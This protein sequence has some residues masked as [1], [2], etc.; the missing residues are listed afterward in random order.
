M[1]SQ[2]NFQDN[3][4]LPR[5]L[6]SLRREYDIDL[7]LDFVIE[8]VGTALRLIGINTKSVK[9]EKMKVVNG[10][11]ITPCYTEQI[12]EIKHC[13]YPVMFE[14][15]DDKIK[16]DKSLTEVDV[17]YTIFST[18]NNGF[19]KII[20]EEIYYA[21]LHWIL[22]KYLLKKF[23]GGT[24]DGNKLQFFENLKDKYINQAR[25]KYKQ[26]EKDR[27]VRTMYS[28]FNRKWK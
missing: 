11:L 25:G 26:G 14:V 4:N 7:E 23:I 16:V 6:D 3:P 27:V 5:L 13:N 22:Y 19:P 15:E 17:T 8:E 10:V 1:I 21:C 20:D 28:T 18:D 24:E 2:Y 12:S 9:T